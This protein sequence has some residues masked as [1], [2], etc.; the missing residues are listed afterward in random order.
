MSYQPLFLGL[1]TAV[2][3]TNTDTNILEGET[4]NLRV[5]QLIKFVNEGN[6]FI[7]GGVVANTVYYIKE[8]IDSN[9]F[10]VSTTLNGVELE[11]TNGEGFMLVRPI[12]REQNTESL[13][14][15]DEM[16]EKI[17]SEGVG[18]GGVGL[19]GDIDGGSAGS[20][21]DESTVGDGILSVVE[22]ETPAL[23]GNLSL[24]GK[25]IFGT[26][27]I[28]ITGTI[29][30]T[31]L[32]GGLRGTVA[33]SLTGPVDSNGI[34]I[35]NPAIDGLEFELGNPTGGQVISWD[36]PNSKFVLT[37]VAAVSGEDTLDDVLFRGNSSLNTITVGR[38]TTPEVE[39]ANDELNIYSNWAKDTGIS[40]YSV[41]D[42]ES[43][44]LT[45]DRI[46]AVVTNVGPSQKQWFFE[47]SGNFKLPAGGDIVDST[48]VS[49]LGGTPF[50]G[51]YDDLTNKPTIPTNTN[52]LTNGAGFITTNGIPSQTGN[53]GKYLTTDG[54]SAS[55]ASV[56]GLSS[57]TT[58]SATTGALSVGGTG[59]I[60]ITGFKTYALLGMSVGIPAWVRLYT[61][62]AART[63]DAARLETED[64]LPGSGIIAEVITTTNNQIVAFTPATI[65][66]N[67][68]NPA[69][70][71]IYA[72]VKN[73]GTGLATIQVTLSLL[74]LEA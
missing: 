66:F 39:G 53:T 48:G 70:T 7:F 47:E 67:G 10:K 56:S 71:T 3:R 16:L 49:V 61:S 54:S 9:E 60:S 45:S 73:K 2:F 33:G 46:V 34:R 11:L 5:G 23:G 20:A 72:S 43:V 38:A 74:Q 24:N 63:A 17:Y 68:D 55:W 31:V 69:A 44:T 32:S 6:G 8:I 13:R 29:N 4:A 28:N 12:Q 36:A 19:G 57:R 14:K 40:I 22:D 65:G 18:G 59:N 21:F 30:A 35:G 58:A 52:Q 1:G 27:A 37:S 64:P 42:L 50:S 15:I 25:T 26:G 51:D 62:A 41:T